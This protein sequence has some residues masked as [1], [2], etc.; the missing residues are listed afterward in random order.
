LQQLPI[1]EL[2][3]EIERRAAQWE[4]DSAGARAHR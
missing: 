2:H 1:E 4:A 3:R